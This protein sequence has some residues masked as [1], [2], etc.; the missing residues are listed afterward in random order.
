MTNSGS[1]ATSFAYTPW[2]GVSGYSGPNGTTG[3]YLYDTYAQPSIANITKGGAVYLAHYP[4]GSFPASYFPG[5]SSG[6]PWA[7]RS[8]Q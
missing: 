3:S 4:G 8:R 1:S 2:L 6:Y 5:S 7:E